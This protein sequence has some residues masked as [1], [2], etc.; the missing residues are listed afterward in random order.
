MQDGDNEDQLP[1]LVEAYVQVNLAATSQMTQKVT[2]VALLLLHI[3]PNFRF[4]VN[5][6]L[7]PLFPQQRPKNFIARIA[8]LTFRP[9]RQRQSLHACIL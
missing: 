7:L 4:L 3:V 5:F 9:N 6:L 1:M 2:P 8:L